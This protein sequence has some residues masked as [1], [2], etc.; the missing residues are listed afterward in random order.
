M[1]TYA[2]TNL[3]SQL[4]KDRKLDH[5][6][7]QPVPGYSSTGQP[8]TAFIGPAEVLPMPSEDFVV[9]AKVTAQ[10]LWNLELDGFRASRECSWGGVFE[11]SGKQWT[12]PHSVW[13]HSAH[14]FSL[15]WGGKRSN[16]HL[17]NSCYATS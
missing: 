11:Q 16:Y 3:Y 9:E 5:R 1:D 15:F 7:H 2:R 6:V 10:L 14:A 13:Q 4:F 17:A 8:N 12:F